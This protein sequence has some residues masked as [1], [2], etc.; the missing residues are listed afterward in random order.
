VKTGCK[1]LLTLLV[2]AAPIAA[3]DAEA[4]K[5]LYGPCAACH[6]PAGGGNKDLNAPAIAGQEQWY[7]I[8]QLQ[9]FKSG[10]RGTQSQDAYGM[11]MAPMAQTLATDADIANVAAYVASLKPAA[12]THDGGGDAAAGQAL[13]ATCAA[14]H[15]PNGQGMESMNAPNLTL[16]QDWYV[17]RQ[18]MNFKSGVRGAGAGDTFGAQMVPM[19]ATVAD[20]QT[21][22]N[23]AAYIATLGG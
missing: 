22:K 12:V 6:G 15:G 7:L 14:C 23:L 17:V 20:E 4:G 11:Q 2:S 5:A 1:V 21:A 13:Y 16:Q 9:N 8:R 18:L 10:V 19:A 3:Q